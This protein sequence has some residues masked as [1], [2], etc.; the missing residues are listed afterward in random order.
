VKPL[1]TTANACLATI[2]ESARATGQLPLT[3][4]Q[5]LSTFATTIP[6]NV[7]DGVPALASP[8]VH[9]GVL[10]VACPGTLSVRDPSTLAQGELPFR[11]VDANTAQELTYDRYVVSVK[12]IYVRRTDRQQN[13]ALPTVTWDGAP[14]AENDV[15]E[16]APCKN[17]PLAAID[18]CD[19]GE[20][21]EVA[22][23]VS[24]ES[25]ESGTS[26]S[27]TPF[28]ED[29]VVQYYGTEGLFEFD[30][31]A[32][33][34]PAVKWAARAAAAG[35]EQTLWF[36]VRENRGGVTWTTRRVRVR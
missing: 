1:E 21:H 22:A 4:G 32:W 31:R 24:P 36:V 25:V 20:K 18:D 6:A 11:C 23:V 26:E 30:A 16:V 19:G 2:V 27:G 12:R 8:N 7:L 9:V 29:V 17:D 35:K 28:S 15:K 34:T 5:G 13:P 33:Q 3:M 10:T 14:W